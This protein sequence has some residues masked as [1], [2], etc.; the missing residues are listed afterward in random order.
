M[1][2][3]PTAEQTAI[4]EAFRAGKDLVV[5]AGAGSGKTTTLK[6]LGEATKRR[7]RYVAYNTAIVAEAKQKMPGNVRCSTGHGLAFPSTGV[8]YK[9]RLNMR[10]QPAREVAQILGIT[11]PARI[12]DHLVLAPAQI[13]RLA[14][15]TVGRFTKTAVGD[16]AP[17]H[18]PTPTGVVD[19]ADIR[20]VRDLVHP[21]ALKVWADITNRAGG[22][23]KVDHD[24]YLKLFQ[25]SE[26]RINA[27][28][29]LFDEAQDAD[30][31]V[32]A[33]IQAQTH[34]QIVAVGD[35][36]QAIY[37][38]RGAVDALARF[39]ETADAVLT[40]S[41]SFRFGPAIAA[42]AN[43]WLDAIN[44]PLRVKGFEQILTARRDRRARRDPVPH[45]R[46]GDRATHG[47]RQ[48]RP[49]RRPPRQDGQ[50]DPRARRRRRAT[51]ERSPARP[52]RTHGVPD[53]GRRP[54]VR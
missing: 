36:A 37:A 8:L 28:F 22:R 42:E 52:P 54:A 44:A 32:M 12:S 25:L 19:E 23:L 4:G 16:I 7:G 15:D 43:K 26:P 21:W 29:I 5:Q 1:S 34:A 13:A 20:A 53:L 38:W 45:Q 41:Q 30:P 24:H 3:T 35:S 40:L 18:V 50:G 2:F 51:P 48:G 49:P 10:Y 27:D 11:Q 14:K 47:R 33:I 31:C 17:W 46:R 39:S 9:D 6:G